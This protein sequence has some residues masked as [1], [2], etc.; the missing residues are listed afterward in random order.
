[1]KINSMAKSWKG[2]FAMEAGKDEMSF[3]K[4]CRR[5]LPG[6]EGQPFWWPGG[7]VAG[8]CQTCTSRGCEFPEKSQLNR[9]GPQFLDLARHIHCRKGEVAFAVE[10]PG[11]LESRQQQGEGSWGPRPQRCRASPCCLP[12]LRGRQA[13]GGGNPDGG[14]KSSAQKRAAGFLLARETSRGGRTESF[15]ENGGVKDNPR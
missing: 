7:A 14:G 9:R 4:A 12:P 8:M 3:G 13:C 2:V 5:L 1:M 6:Q 15:L 10:S 11:G